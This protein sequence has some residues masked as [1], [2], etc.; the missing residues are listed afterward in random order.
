MADKLAVLISTY[1]G[2]DDV[3]V[4]EASDTRLK[5]LYRPDLMPSPRY[6]ADHGGVKPEM[7]DQQNAEW[8]D[9]LGQADVAFDFDW[10]APERLGRTS[11]EAEMGAGNERRGRRIHEADGAGQSTDLVVTTA[12]GIHAVPLA[13]FAVT[14]RT[15]FRQGHSATCPRSSATH[16][17]G[18]VHD[19]AVGR[20][21]RHRGR[22]GRHRAPGRWPPSR[23]LGT[24]VIAVGRP[25]REYDL[26]AGRAADST[27]RMLS[28]RPAAD[29]RA[30]ALLPADPR[31]TEGLHRRRRAGTASR[32]RRPGQHLAWPGGRRGRPDRRAC[33][34]RAILGAAWMFF[35]AEPLAA[36]SPLWDLDNVLVSPHSA[37]TVATENPTI[38]DLFTDNIQRW[39]SGRTAAQPLPTRAGLL[40][41]E[42]GQMT[43]QPPDRYLVHRAD[44]VRRRRATSTQRVCDG[45]RSS[46]VVAVDGITILGVMGEAPALSDLE[47]DLVL[48]TVAESAAGRLPFAVGC[49]S[50]S[51]ALTRQRVLAG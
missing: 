40:M 18:A 10:Q 44:A 30:R 36:D 34:S 21:H 39:L 46:R 24:T 8:A 6:T 45:R 19:R 1:V 48:R 29:R 7:T 16:T 38:V 12:A 17:L 20:P 25:G 37:S 50:P 31:Q 13:E 27:P 41:R 2:A 9:L 42:L 22:P 33:S 51:A 35:T 11:T 3:S 15:T 4:I 14:G 32:L 28:A 47:R 43:E 26:P 23:A 49:S 5:V